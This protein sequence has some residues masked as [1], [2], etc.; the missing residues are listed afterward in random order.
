MPRVLHQLNSLLDDLAHSQTD[1]CLGVRQKRTALAATTD[2]SPAQ[3]A[4]FQYESRAAHRAASFLGATAGSEPRASSSS[5]VEVSGSPPAH[6][7]HVPAPKTSFWFWSSKCRRGDIWGK[8][9]DKCGDS[10]DKCDSN[11]CIVFEGKCRGTKVGEDI[12]GHDVKINDWKWYFGPTRP[13]K[14]TGD[15]LKFG[16]Y[17][18]VIGPG[19]GP[20]K[21]RAKMTEA[22]KSPDLDSNKKPWITMY[23]PGN[24]RYIEVKTLQG[25]APHP[26]YDHE[27]YSSEAKGIMAEYQFALHGD[28]NP[29]AGIMKP[30]DKMGRIVTAS[31]GTF[32]EDNQACVTALPADFSKNTGK[33]CWHQFIPECPKAECPNYPYCPKDPPCPAPYW[34]DTCHENAGQPWC[35]PPDVLKQYRGPLEIQCSA[36]GNDLRSKVGS[37]DG[38]WWLAKNAPKLDLQRLPGKINRTYGPEE[39]WFVK[40]EKGA[41]SEKQAEKWIETGKMIDD[42]KGKNSEYLKKAAPSKD[43]A[44]K[45]A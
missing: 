1:S 18:Q 20:G 6:A 19:K 38:C 7:A 32:C 41:L 21:A 17:G 45:T 11:D 37:P 36:T 16:T 29:G 39:G 15:W 30:C 23:F 22:E 13:Y 2:V 4:P 14:E 33:F 28:L 31:D 44:L 40:H 8:D 10:F 3:A 26:L 43:A 42:T 34:Q 35:V 9:C 27:P 25:H 24:K 5:A 12:D